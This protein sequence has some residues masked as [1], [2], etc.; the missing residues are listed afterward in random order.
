MQ[1]QHFADTG[2][3]YEGYI[4]LRRWLNLTQD[5]SG[6]RSHPDYAEACFAAKHTAAQRKATDVVLGLAARC[7][8]TCKRAA[9]PGDAA[10]RAQARQSEEESG[11]FPAGNAPVAIADGETHLRLPTKRIG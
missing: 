4:F 7:R 1:G 11:H 8:D 5:K 6:I 3:P 9:H 10:P 2:K